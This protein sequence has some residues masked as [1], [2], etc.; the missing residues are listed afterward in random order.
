MNLCVEYYELGKYEKAEV[1]LERARIFLDHPSLENNK[2]AFFIAQF[3]LYMKTER[4][5]LVREQFQMLMELALHMKDRSDFWRDMELLCNLALDLNEL[6]AMKKILDCMQQQV[7]QFTNE[8]LGLDVK[9]RI[10]EML[11][12]YYKAVG[13]EEQVCKCELEYI[14][15][16]QMQYQEVKK[17][18]AAAIDYK[19]QLNMQ[20]EKNILYKKQIDID[21]LTGVGN[22]YKLE[23]DYKVLKDICCKKG[24]QVG[25]G[26]IDLDYFKLVN[27]TYGHL[28]GDCYLKII[29]EIIREAIIS[30]GG[31]H[32]YGGDEFVV[33]LADV[34]ADMIQQIAEKIEHSI[35]KKKL[36]NQASEKKMLTVSQGY[37]IFDASTNSDIW[38]ALPFADQPVI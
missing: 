10:H 35:K 18:R 16:C 17:A 4:E 1:L 38:Q 30:T 26:I 3:R 34:D 31:V 36:K 29:S 27:D 28:Q 25:V 12:T 9:V 6:D 2:L 15:L 14:K 24:C 11:L 7:N 13:N 21:Q 32:R 8:R 23:K 22:R 20:Y 33:L 5:E 19:I 37:I